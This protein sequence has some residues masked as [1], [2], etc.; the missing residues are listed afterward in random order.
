MTQQRV[1]LIL[2]FVNVLVSLATAI[3]IFYFPAR[4][5]EI[6]LWVT[7]I[8]ALAAAIVALAFNWGTNAFIRTR[9]QERLAVM[10][11]MGVEVQRDSQG[12]AQFAAVPQLEFRE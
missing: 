4:Q 9:S 10:H 3:A 1:E 11:A 2:Q 8:Q 7:A 5:I 6:N 12:V